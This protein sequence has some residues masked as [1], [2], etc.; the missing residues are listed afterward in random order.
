MWVWTWPK[1]N[2]C[3]KKDQFKSGPK[4]DLKISTFW[5]IFL[6]TIRQFWITFKCLWLKWNL[7]GEDYSFVIYLI[8]IFFLERF[9]PPWLC[10]FQLRIGPSKSI[11]AEPFI[12]NGNRANVGDFPWH[13]SLFITYHS[14][15]PNAEPS[16]CS[17]A[18]LNEKWV[19]TPAECIF[20]SR[21]IRVDVGSVD[22]NK[23]LISVF[24]DSFTL[25]PQYD[26]NKFKNN[27]ALLRLPSN[28][29]LDFTSEQTK[30][31]IAPIRLPRKSQID[32]D[33]VDAESYYSS[34]GYPSP[35]NK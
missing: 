17:G 25:H 14:D 32:S 22:I 18:I 29:L 9:L 6:H 34:F 7:F 21:T 13:A 27:I 26:Q 1:S 2:F 16:H 23:P 10:F 5:N 31:K 28:S 33:F 8:S 3:K 15:A 30:G 19:L 20:N 35:S 24:P 12:A 11:N 4:I